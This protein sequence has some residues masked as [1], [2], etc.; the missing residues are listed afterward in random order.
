MGATRAGE[1][2]AVCSLWLIGNL[3]E[4]IHIQ[5]TENK[6]KELGEI[7][8]RFTFGIFRPVILV[9]GVG[10]A[11]T[12]ERGRDPALGTRQAGKQAVTNSTYVESIRPVKGGSKLIL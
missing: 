4:Q 7:F 5:G 2:G 6:V 1:F 12:W 8:F 10:S 11:K 9:V 3:L